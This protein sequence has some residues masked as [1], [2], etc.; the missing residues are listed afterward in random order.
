MLAAF[1]LGLAMGLPC[2]WVGVLIGI[3]FYVEIPYFLTCHMLTKI[4]GLKFC[5]HPWDIFLGSLVAILAYFGRCIGPFLGSLEF[6]KAKNDFTY[7][8]KR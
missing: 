8:T 4:K 7:K 2:V 5:V 3:L 1:I 6:K